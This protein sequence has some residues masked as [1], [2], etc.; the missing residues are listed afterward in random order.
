[1]PRVDLFHMAVDLAQQLLLFGEVLLRAHEDKGHEHEP[2]QRRADGYV[3]A[4]R[5]SVMNIITVD[6]TSSVT[7]EIRPPRDWFM[8]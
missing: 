7:A 1:M 5:Q 6:P 3:N 8:V 4:R 2:E